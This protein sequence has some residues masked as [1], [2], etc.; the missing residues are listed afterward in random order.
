V[1]GLGN[2]NS[3]ARPGALLGAYDV[4]FAKSRS[5]IEALA[6]GTAVILCAPGRL[7]PMV[8]TENFA[9]LRQWNFGIRTLDQP[10]DVDLIAAELGKYNSADAA[11]VSQ[12]T[13]ATCE[14]Q[15]AVDRLLEIYQRVLAA[16]PHEPADRTRGC[17]SAARYLERWA[18][19]YKIPFG[20]M[21]D[22]D[23]WMERCRAAEQALAGREQ[24]LTE[25]SSAAEKALAEEG[26]LREDAER[27]AGEMSALLSCRDADVARLSREL[28]DV[29]SSAAENALAEQGLREDA[30]RQT[31]QMSALLSCRDRDVARL[32]WDLAALRSSASWRWTQGLLQNFLVQVLFGGLIRSV[33]R[34][35]CPVPGSSSGSQSATT[36]DITLGRAQGG[37]TDGG[38]QRR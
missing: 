37:V 38:S 32:S 33:A 14:L 29:R 25:A 19:V 10:L 2:G 18:P 23:H 11:E 36:R 6:V 8:T 15:P 7:G 20:I 22:R 28:A 24:R 3:T 34:H 5:A 17:D 35:H 26:R 13:R 9:S 21:A 4:V 31:G 12:L 1:R 30:E 16:A 27:R